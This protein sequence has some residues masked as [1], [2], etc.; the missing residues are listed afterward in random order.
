MTKEQA[1]ELLILLAALEAWAVSKN[2]E[3]LPNYLIDNLL[4]C[5]DMLRE[6]VLKENT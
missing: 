6:V 5:M 1:L 4:S 3:D 2:K